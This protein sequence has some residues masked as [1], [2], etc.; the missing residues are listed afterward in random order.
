[1]NGKNKFFMLGLILIVFLSLGCVCAAEN[2]TVSDD[3]AQNSLSDNETIAEDNYNAE[4]RVD[5]YTAKYSPYNEFNV[6]L[7][8]DFGD[9]IT[10]EDVKLV[11]NGGKQESL[12]EWDDYSGYNTY[13]DKNVGN[14]KA[15][16]VLKS[17]EFNAYP[18]SINLKILK[19]NVK[20][21]PK[22][23]HTTQNHYATLKT[24][25][26]DHNGETVDEG[27]VKF[28]INGKSYNVKVKNGVAIKKVKL[29]KARIYNYRATFTGN[30]YYSK[31]ATSKVY[32]YSTS[33]SARTFTNGKYKYTLSLS[34]YKKLVN[35]KNTHK[36][37]YLELKTGKYIK[38][39]YRQ[40]SAFGKYAY[41]TV[42]ARVIFCICYGGKSGAQGAFPNMYSM[43]FT[44]KYQFPDSF[45][46]PSIVGYKMSSQINK[47]NKAKLITY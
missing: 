31:S 1:M 35:G 2:Q 32:V 18:V 9:E 3:L 8:D 25:V 29:S 36:M 42:N 17:S 47:L 40:Y 13:I 41:K 7:F 39:T 44:T 20:L 37:I 11:W 5:D 6:L 16:V 19:A 45:A 46:T 27:T 30:N 15:T 34:N 43:R 21:Y 22:V 28:T 14:Y 33:K 24:T 4:F 23:Y 26:Y 38:Q 12:Y 10:G